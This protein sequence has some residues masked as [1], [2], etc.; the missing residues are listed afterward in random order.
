MPKL[1]NQELIKTAC[2]MINR[3]FIALST[4][5]FLLILQSAVFGQ[6]FYKWTDENGNVRYSDS[7]P[8]QEAAVSTVDIAPGPTE[9]QKQQAED[10]LNQQT[11]ASEDYRSRR[12]AEEAARASEKKKPVAETTTVQEEKEDDS[13]S[14]NARRCQKGD[15]GWPCT[16]PPPANLPSNPIY[17]PKPKPGLPVQ[18]PANPVTLPAKTRINP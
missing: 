11:Q 8:A 7:P 9:A 1:I 16:R 2:L 15:I 4:F 17:R 3:L 13:G 18:M 6:Q 14:R 12:E 5:T 10:R